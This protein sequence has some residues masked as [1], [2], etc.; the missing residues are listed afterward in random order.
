IEGLVNAAATFDPELG[1]FSTWACLRI[2]RE[3]LD[4]RNRLCIGQYAVPRR[5]L[6]Q[7]TLVRTAHESLRSELGREV[8]SH[9]VAER[10][11]LSFQFV[12]TILGRIPDLELD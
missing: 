1:G 8:G 10:V 9:E 6:R 3:I 12:E 4:Q 2:R 7:A 5:A 11:G